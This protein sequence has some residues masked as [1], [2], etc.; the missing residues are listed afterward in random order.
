MAGKV[1]LEGGLGKWKAK[2]S[3]YGEQIVSPY[4]YSV[5]YFKNLDIANQGYSFVGPKQ[6][7]FFV[8]TSIYFQANKNVSASTAADVVLFESND[9][10]NV[11]VSKSIYQF[12]MVR[13]DV[14]SLTSLN[15]KISE[16]KYLNGKTTDDDVLATISG[17][18]VIC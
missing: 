3:R 12:E 1:T 16:G 9:E 4:D 2:V 14:I 10:D 13:R 15:I 18:Y 8:I 17:Y 6:G 5:S 11:T 7:Q